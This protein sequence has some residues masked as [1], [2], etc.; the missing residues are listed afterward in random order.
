VAVAV[1]VAVGFCWRWICWDMYVGLVVDGA[2]CHLFL[3]PWLG[4]PWVVTCSGLVTETH[5]LPHTP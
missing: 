3:M 5:T 4:K 1:A 2:V